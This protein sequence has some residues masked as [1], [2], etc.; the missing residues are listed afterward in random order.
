MINTSYVAFTDAAGGT[1]N[2]AY[3][4][5]IGHK[6][7]ENFIID[8]VRGTRSGVRFDSAIVTE[9]YVALL[10]YYRIYSVTGDHYVAA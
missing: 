8:A 7:G 4:I 10:K 3:A 6:Q 5:A 1:G 2:D 9:E